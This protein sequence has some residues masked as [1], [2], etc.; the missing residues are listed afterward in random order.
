MQCINCK[1][2]NPDSNSHCLECGMALPL[3][4]ANSFLT[5]SETADP[6]PTP[7]AH[8]LSCPHCSYRFPF[9]WWRNFFTWNGRYKCQA[10]GQKSYLA[11]EEITLK[12]M[13]PAIFGGS[14]CGLLFI[15][16]LSTTEIVVFHPL[17]KMLLI[18]FSQNIPAVMI[19]V[20]LTGL[21]TVWIEVSFPWEKRIL[22][23]SRR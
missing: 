8:Y 6:A 15:W 18:C 12:N 22:V 14:A 21:W 13:A 5:F 16:Q 2:L 9:R 1:I 10:C 23:R 20:L 11:G 17:P 7:A 3:K 4:S 19:I